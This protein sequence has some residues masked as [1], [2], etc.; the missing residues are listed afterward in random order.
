MLRLATNLS[1]ALFKTGRYEEAV[2][3]G[4]RGLDSGGGA[5][6]GA[7]VQ[8]DAPGQHRRAVAR[9]GT[10]AGGGAL[11]QRGL[12]LDAPL[13]HARQ[14]HLL[15]AELRAWQDRIDESET[16]LATLGGMLGK[17]SPDLQLTMGTRAARMLVA[18]RLR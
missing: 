6:T 11:I 2:D 12:D 5:G 18:S 1:D 14:F 10:V 15:L 16:M 8:P 17:V 9:F 13:S 4:Q 7:E 3:A